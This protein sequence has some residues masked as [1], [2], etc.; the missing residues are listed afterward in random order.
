[1]KKVFFY[2]LISAISCTT[3]F[4]QGSLKKYND[5]ARLFSKEVYKFDTILILCDTALILNN[6]TYNLYNSVYQNYR[7][8]N[9]SCKDIIGAYDELVKLQ[10]HR[11]SQLNDDYR[12]LRGQFDSLASQSLIVI[13]N[14]K[15]N[16]TQISDTLSNVTQGL[17]DTKKLIKDAQDIIAKQQ[18]KFF[19]S[20]LTWGLGGC[21]FGVGLASAVFLLAR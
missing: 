3:V 5:C 18:I 6:K 12:A 7:K 19:L 2:F 9:S 4:S 17:N 8:N 13:N 1:M 10:D 14:T 16:L 21:V 11:I 15:T 20:R